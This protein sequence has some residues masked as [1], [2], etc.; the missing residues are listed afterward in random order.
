MQWTSRNE[1]LGHAWAFRNDY[2]DWTYITSNMYE[3]YV[4]Y[5]LICNNERRESCAHLFTFGPINF[6]GKLVSIAVAF[7]KT[8]R[9]FWQCGWRYGP[10]S[11]GRFI[12]RYRRMWFVHTVNAGRWRR[13]CGAGCE[14]GHVG[15]RWGQN[16]FGW[17]HRRWTLLLCMRRLWCTHLHISHWT[18]IHFDSV[19]FLDAK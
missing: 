11:N 7:G 14:I 15:A 3:N 18:Q 17:W 9:V 16:W 10:C 13:Y 4:I 6:A 2:I 1:M 5:F 8:G 12:A 19:L